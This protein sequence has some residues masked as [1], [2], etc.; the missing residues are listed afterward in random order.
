MAKQFIFMTWHEVEGYSE[1]IASFDALEDAIDYVC[2]YCDHTVPLDPNHFAYDKENF[3]VT[4]F[5]IF[6]TDNLESVYEYK[7]RL[8]PLLET[9]KEE[10]KRIKTKSRGQMAAKGTE[11]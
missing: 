5:E 1:P 11:L 9:K 6:D 3:L 10:V 8:K 2:D 7:D 4:R